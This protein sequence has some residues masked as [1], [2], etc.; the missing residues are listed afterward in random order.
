VA[1]AL[2]EAEKKRAEDEV[3]NCKTRNEKRKAL[4]VR[5]LNSQGVDASKFTDD[6]IGVAF[7]TLAAMQKRTGA[8]GGVLPI[9]GKA[10]GRT[11][12]E[13]TPAR[14]PNFAQRDAK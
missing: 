5:V 11:F 4:T 1:N 6:Q 10:T 9:S 2:P 7:K 14:H 3:K 12:N 13:Q 8:S